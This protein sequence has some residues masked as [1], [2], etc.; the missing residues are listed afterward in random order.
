MVYEI[1][2]WKSG[3]SHNRV[4][5]QSLN[6]Y[7]ILKTFETTLN[8]IDDLEVIICNLFRD[9]YL[10]YSEWNTKSKILT[11]L[12]NRCKKNLDVE[13]MKINKRKRWWKIWKS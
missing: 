4:V 7:D 11:E 1:E 13:E 8:G 12:E 3:N 10:I 2:W 9:D 5:I 6:Q